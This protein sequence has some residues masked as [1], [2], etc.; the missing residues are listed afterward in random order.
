MAKT[1]KTPALEEKSPVHE[2]AF[3]VIESY[4]RVGT[5]P[6]AN[7]VEIRDCGIIYADYDLNTLAGMIEHLD[8]N[9]NDPHRA[10]YILESWKFL[11]QE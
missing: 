11:S 6:T 4:Y 8:K 7:P 9:A 2:F 5:M 3:Y 10:V 1:K